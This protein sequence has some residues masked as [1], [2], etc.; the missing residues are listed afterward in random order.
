MKVVIVL[1]NMDPTKK[2]AFEETMCKS[3]IEAF[4]AEAEND[5]VETDLGSKWVYL[6][7]MTK[8]NEYIIDVSQSTIMDED[9]LKHV[10]EAY[11]VPESLS[12]KDMTICL[13]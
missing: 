13:E 5:I 7:L 8:A 12:I 9:R 6:R 11:E 3:N 4:I 2:D 10:G 1:E